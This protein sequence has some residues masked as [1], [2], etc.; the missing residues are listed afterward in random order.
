[1]NM[2]IDEIYMILENSTNISYDDVLNMSL[3]EKNRLLGFIERRNKK[4]QEM[5]N[6]KNKGIK[7]K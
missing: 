2:I 3:Y 1:M 6:S 4:Q 7:K 5:I